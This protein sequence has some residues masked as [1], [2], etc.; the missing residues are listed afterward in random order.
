L[1]ITICWKIACLNAS[2]YKSE[3]VI[4]L[5]SIK[6]MCIAQCVVFLRNYIKGYEALLLSN[7]VC[8][9]Y[10][11][12]LN[13]MKGI[14]KLCDSSDLLCVY[15]VLFGYVCVLFYLLTQ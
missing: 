12:V 9:M 2:E 8:L 11:V 14:I 3:S 4:C 5:K 13:G 7:I 1:E 6:R 15:H 10:I